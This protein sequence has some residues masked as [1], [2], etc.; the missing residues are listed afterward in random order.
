M[1]IITVKAPAKVNLSLDIVGVRPDGYHLLEMVMQTVSL[2]D[3]VTLRP[4]RGEIT[5]TCDDP[6]VPCDRRNIAYRAAQRFL[7]QITV[8]AADEDRKGHRDSLSSDS[9]INHQADAGLSGIHIAIQKRIP[10][11]AGLAGGSADGAAVLVGL[12]RMYGGIL[13]TAELC[14]IGVQIGAD[15]PF[16]IRGGTAFVEGIGE[17]VTPLPPLTGCHILIAKPSIGIETAASFK[18]YDE[19]GS[20]FRPK[21]KQL[22][23]AIAARDIKLAAKS[24]GNVL[25]T[26]QRIEPVEAIVSEMTALGADGSVMTGSGSAV[27]GLYR[28]AE[29]AGHAFEAMREKY[30]QCYLTEPVSKGAVCVE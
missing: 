2:Y 18:R 28:D 1:E 19:V 8:R 6:A 9:R 17:H 26:M 4:D 7:E 21:T 5:I 14:E 30:D 25:Q 23:Q 24:M 20:R 10:A 29:K 15:L 16:C 12:N 3:T 22:K 11:Q 27:I 13:S